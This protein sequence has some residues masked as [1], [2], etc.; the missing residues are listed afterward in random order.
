[1]PDDVSSSLLLYRDGLSQS[2]RALAALDP[3]SVLVDER[4]LA[5]WLRFL[6][7]YAGQLTYYDLS[8]QPDPGRGWSGLFPFTDDQCREIAA[9]AEDPER[10]EDARYDDYR[11]P[12]FALLL[13]FLGVLRPVQDQLNAFTRRHLDF[14][15]RDVLKFAR[16]PAVSGR[17]HVLLQPRANQ[18]PF[19]LPAG[20]LLNA[21]QDGLG[22]DVHYRTD[23][24]RVVNQARVSQCRSL[25]LERRVVGLDEVRQAP[26][27]LLGFLH[28]PVAWLDVVPLHE[29]RFQALLEV[30][31]GDPQ[32][33]DPLPPYPSNPN[34]DDAPRPAAGP[35]R[36]VVAE[37]ALFG[38]LD[39]LVAFIRRELFLGLPAFRNLMA[40]RRGLRL[41]NPGIASD[42]AAVNTTL[43]QAGRRKRKDDAYQLPLDRIDDFL[44]NLKTALNL[45]DKAYR[46]LYDTLPEVSDV[47]GLYRRIDQ[48]GRADIATF[49]SSTLNLEVDEFKDMMA[50]V[51]RVYQPWRQVL[52]ILRA[53]GRRKQR[54]QPNHVVAP[55]NLRAYD[56]DLWSTLLRTTLGNVQ[57]NLPPVAGRTP[58]DLDEVDAELDRLEQS[59]QM[60]AEDFAKAR[61]VNANDEAKP[62]E[63]TEVYQI[64][65][66][67]RRE[68]E[69]A[70]R[71]QRLKQQRAGTA[72]P[73]AGL[74]AMVLAAL[75][76]P[77]PDDPK[78]GNQMPSYSRSFL[79]LDPVADAAHIREALFLDPNEVAVLQQLAS[80]ATPPTAA[81]WERAA[82]ILE[83]AQRQKQHWTPPPLQF[84]AWDNVYAAADATLVRSSRPTDN[85]PSAPRWRTFGDGA[86]ADGATAPARLGFMIASPL[87]A[88]AEGERTI[89]LTLGF[90]E[91]GYPS[92]GNAIRSALKAG[93]MPFR[94]LL[95]TAKGMIEIAPPSVEITQ[96]LSSPGSG[97]PA[98][99]RMLR[100]VLR[101]SAQTPAVGPPPPGSALLGAQPIL[102]VLLQ[103]LSDPAKPDAPPRKAYD[104]FRQLVLDR[105]HL[106]VTVAGLTDLLLQNDEA[107]LNPK[108]PFE[109]FG[110]APVSGSRFLF[111]HPEICTKRLDLLC[112]GIDWL[113]A[114]DDLGA[115][116]ANY[117]AQ[118]PP[119]AN[120]ASFVAHW[121]LCD[122]R[123][124]FDLKDV[125]LFAGG[126][127]GADQQRLAGVTEP[128][129]FGIPRDAI[130]ARYP[131]YQASPQARMG[132]EPLACDRY[133]VL[134]LGRPDFLHSIYPQAAARAATTNT[135]PKIL[136]P[137][138][139]PR[140]KRLRVYYQASV[141]LDPLN[142]G[143][144]AADQLFYVEPFGYR[145]ITVRPKTADAA[146]WLPQHD[147][148][149]ELYLGLA[150]VTPPQNL[151]F[152][153]Q[154][155]AGSADPDVVP[156]PVRWSYLSDNQWVDLDDRHLLSDTTRGLLNAGLIEFDLPPAQSSTL[157][158]A[159]RYWIRAAIAR[160]S[161]GV[162]EVVDI[163][164]QAVSASLVEGPNLDGAG[165]ALAPNRITG[166]VEARPEVAAVQQPYSSFGG[167][168]AE[169][170]RHF[171]IRVS[172]RLRHKGRALTCWDYERLVLETFPEIYKVKCLAVDSVDDP[173]RASLVQVIVIP[174]IRGKRPFDPF[175]PKVPADTL[176]RIEEFLANCSAAGAPFRVQ[177][178]RY[179]SLKLRFSVRLRPGCNP[180]FYLAQLDE[181]VRRFLA[182]WAYDDSADIVF[183]GRVSANLIVHFVEQRPYVDYVAGMKL[184]LSQNGQILDR[185]AE[186][187]VDLRLFTG[188]APDVI[189]VSAPEHQI[190]L[191]AEE[192][193]VKESFVGIDYLKVELDFRVA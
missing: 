50:I 167:S 115:W 15:Y 174:D 131:A 132:A 91:A 68:K 88:L 102:Q 171:R 109:P 188:G 159:D 181:E 99:T 43:E 31:L 139:T 32:P 170:D 28:R 64:L 162:C 82:S 51:D 38:D 110:R 184:F 55:P 168:P 150:G 176:R 178:P 94:F 20:T 36:G 79:K 105:V 23:A 134:E 25:F 113:G 119:I 183:G 62:W 66:A 146:T 41:S 117:P 78:H 14:Y 44:T 54:K 106:Q 172:E 83:P 130:E 158:P 67:A 98:Y 93:G 155:A 9:F 84:E 35:A 46:T 128:A 56:P 33:G 147:N 118:S 21:G 17:V 76:D 86:R 148:E 169:E 161:R 30:A 74:E 122:R 163:R 12:H 156:P 173:R 85:D 112:V 42:W 180:G 29:K 101:L 165:A 166:L 141:E 58:A 53:A 72:N 193:Y 138:Y 136:N 186:D 18:V 108:K 103:D 89:T 192:R 52:E 190:D 191:I 126:G 182:P 114:P 65:T 121:Q 152:L 77:K 24:D 69:L 63:W 133:W 154:M 16:R 107:G 11:R 75:G 100:F 7:Q 39:R 111:A 97:L 47:Y 140:I 57:A 175:E 3:A 145:L 73:S 27:V 153:F 10:F 71:R 185:P 13:A 151:A 95:S 179:C 2:A 120:N 96:D 177:N 80:Q 37:K 144:T 49:V 22:N 19:L 40:L 104:A 60:G 135:P 26:E 137:P 6:K 8:N 81:D 1:M 4:S 59:F 189:L 160:H 34:P 143:P 187:H 123:A 149:G 125:A 5:D 87:L 48:P 164:T 127:D 129:W 90:T 116:Y 61:A 45:T 92:A 124:G 157:L 70:Q 142:N